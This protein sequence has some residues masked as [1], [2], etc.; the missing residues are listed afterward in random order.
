[1]RPY[2]PFWS[3]LFAINNLENAIHFLIDIHYEK[4]HIETLIHESIR[5]D[6]DQARRLCQT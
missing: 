4:T 2:L 3:T 6:P 1:M 5:L